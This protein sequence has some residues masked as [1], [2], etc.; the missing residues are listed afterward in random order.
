[1]RTTR[2]PEV[3][4]P[5]AADRQLPAVA[6][7]RH[8]PE[9]LPRPGTTITTLTRDQTEAVATVL[10][11]MREPE[12]AA[13]CTGLQKEVA[14]RQFLRPATEQPLPEVT[15]GLIPLLP[16]VIAVPLRVVTVHHRLHRAVTARQH[17]AIVL[18]R[19]RREAIARPLAEEVDARWVAE[20]AAVRDKFTLTTGLLVLKYPSK[21]HILKGISFIFR[22]VYEIY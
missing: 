6:G 21:D 10:P 7:S 20:V 4:S 15:A 5:E 9:A 17:V 11:E 12:P 14:L 19:L 16:E 8:L 13:R 1:M 22:L 2:G 18:L 3:Q